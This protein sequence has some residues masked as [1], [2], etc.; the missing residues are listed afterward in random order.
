MKTVNN[1]TFFFRESDEFSNWFRRNFQVKGITF[2][3]M[4][5]FI[6][7][8]KAMLFS[9]LETARKILAAVH[10]R[11]Q[12]NLGRSVRNYDDSVWTARRE[13][14]ALAGCTEK[15]RQNRDLAATLLGTGSTII[16]EASPYDRVW[17]IGLAVNDPLILDQKNWRGQNLQGNVLMQVRSILADIGRCS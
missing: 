8:A 5:Q 2:N 3:C 15:F 11:D 6:M 14:I 13:R 17:G 16:G 4:E 7:Y 1:F 9:D 12:K 10:P